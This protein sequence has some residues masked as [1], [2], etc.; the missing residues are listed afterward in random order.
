M[1]GVTCEQK[2]CSRLWIGKLFIYSFIHFKSILYSY[3]FICIYFLFP[4]ALW[5]R[6]RRIAVNRKRLVNKV[7]TKTNQP[8][9]D[10]H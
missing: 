4:L 3:I 7:L 6:V 1:V 2:L 5:E 10:S 8:I 9:V